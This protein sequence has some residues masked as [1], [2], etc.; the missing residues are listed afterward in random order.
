MEDKPEF[1]ARV[2]DS[3]VDAMLLCEAGGLGEIR[4]L[5]TIEHAPDLVVGSPAPLPGVPGFDP[6]RLHCSL[7][8]L[9]RSTAIVVYLDPHTV[10]V[11]T[12]PISQINLLSTK[13]LANPSSSGSKAAFEG[14]LCGGPLVRPWLNSGRRR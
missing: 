4:M 8:E 3:Q 9:Q 6:L 7:D 5:A 1:K 11:L 2:R 10:T 13:T 12:A 14:R